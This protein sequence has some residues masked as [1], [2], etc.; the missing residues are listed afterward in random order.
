MFEKEFVL[1]FFTR[2]VERIKTEKIL[3][4]ELKFDFLKNKVISIIGPRRSGKTY[5]LLNVL[6]KNKNII[7]IDL[8]HSA[9]REITHK[10]FFEIISVFEEYFNTKVE[11][12]LIDEIQRLNNWESLVRSL[13]DSG[14]YLMISG[15]SS[16]LLSKEIATQLRGRSI[17]YLFLPLSFREYL[18]FKNVERKKFLSISEKVKTIKLLE[19]FLEWGSYPEILIYP[20]KREKI[21]REYFDTIFQKDFVER[22]EIV[23]TYVAKLIFEFIL[24]NFS[25][26]ISL[27]KISNF[28]SSRIGKNLKNVVYDYAKKLP[29]SLSVFFVEK[30]SKSVY[31]RKSLGRKV[32]ICDLGLASALSIERDMGKRMENVVFLELL[33]KTNDIPLLEIFYFKDYQQN[34]VDFVLKEGLKIKQLI[35]V[36]YSSSKDEIE[37][38][39]IKSLLKASSLLKCKNLLIITWDY[40][41]EI[42]INNKKIVF[43]PLWKWLLQI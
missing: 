39:E 20:E 1:Q 34:E 30:F 4:R 17:T 15:S 40:E 38:R 27:N 42:K 35:Q 36:T 16:K 23:N 9:F 7:Y 6:R 19:E 32:Y 25:K 22:F 31:E 21:L 28:V 3:D 14:Y 18:D 37:K 41:D 8:E 5:F 13:L 24:Q 12:V 26:E 2:L 33:R 11:K 29:E 10:D 43:K